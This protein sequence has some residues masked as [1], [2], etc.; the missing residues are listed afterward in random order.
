MNANLV[1]SDRAKV[2]ITQPLNDLFASLAKSFTYDDTIVVL[3]S[4]IVQ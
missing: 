2:Y 1:S 3:F 4:I